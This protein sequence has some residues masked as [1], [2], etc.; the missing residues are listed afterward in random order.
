[1]AWQL[2]LQGLPATVGDLDQDSHNNVG[3]KTRRYE[4]MDVEL[5][6]ACD[7]AF[8]ETRLYMKL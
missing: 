8:D 1:V 6:L 2:A 5:H 7:V 3:H 4:K